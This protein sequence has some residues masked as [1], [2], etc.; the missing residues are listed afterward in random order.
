MSTPKVPRSLFWEK[1]NGI[2]HSRAQSVDKEV[3]GRWDYP[4]WKR[5]KLVLPQPPRDTVWK[6]HVLVTYKQHTFPRVLKM[7]PR[8]EKQWIGVYWGLHSHRQHLLILKLEEENNSFYKGCVSVIRLLLLWPNR[9]P[10]TYTNTTILEV[11]TW[12]HYNSAITR[13]LR[14]QQKM[15]A[16]H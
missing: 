11:R 1:K 3:L 7:D 8:S 10:P 9:I 6:Y 2:R 12:T 5:L 13:T 16:I 14:P 4:L 15:E